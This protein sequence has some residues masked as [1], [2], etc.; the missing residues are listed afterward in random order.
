MKKL[1]FLLTLLLTMLLM[2]GVAYAAKCDAC[3]SSN[4]QNIGSGAWCHW[5]C[6]DCG[7][8]TSRNHN[9]N[10]YNCGLVPASCSGK[11]SWCGASAVW[12]S[13]SFTNWVPAG[14][15]TCL[16]DG[17]ETAVC[18]NAQCS[19]STSRNA[20]GSAL[21][22]S[23]AD[24][25]VAPSCTSAGYTRHTCSRCGDTYEDEEKSALSHSFST[26]SHNGDGTHT[27]VCAR[28][29]CYHSLTAECAPVTSVVGG[30]TI[31]LCPICGHV[32]AP[33][34]PLDLI[35]SKNTSAKSLDGAK[36]PGRL[37]V[38]VDAA[39]LDVPLS[40]D[41]FYMFVTAFQY[42]GKAVEHSGKVQITIDLNEHPFSMPGSIFEGMPPFQ[43]MAR[44]FKIVRVEQEDLDGQPTEVW[45]ELDFTLWNG[46]LTFETDRMGTFLMVL[47]IEGAPSVG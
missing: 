15:A 21:G 40:T 8:R 7:S 33:D 46:I 4:V 10:S 19:A 18:A 27:A 47:N 16:K 31:T 11:C 25:V 36:L 34:T 45:H 12:S 9:P 5:D 20:P 39:P 32:T 44:A 29:K 3:G 14:D 22:H 24:T 42:S 30:Q 23:Y 13:H 26:W 1:F 41:A 43:L 37:M 35:T 28:Q 38:L 2:T 6:A 17:T